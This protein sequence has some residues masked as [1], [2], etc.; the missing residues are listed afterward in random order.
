[1]TITRPEL[2]DLIEQAERNTHVSINVCVLGEVARYHAGKANTPPTVDVRIL[3]RMLLRNGIRFNP[4]IISRVPIGQWSFGPVVIRAVPEVGDGLVCHVF[5]REILTW[6]TKNPSDRKRNYDPVSRRTHDP[7]DIIAF[8]SIRP[9]LRNPSGTDTPRQIYIGHESGKG[10]HLKVNVQT[11][12]IALEASSTVDTKAGTS[13]TIEAA[14]VKLGGPTATLGVAR[15][16]DTVGADVTMATWIAAV[17]AFVNG[18]APGT[19][20]LPSDFGKVSS[21]SSKVKSE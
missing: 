12:A 7:N 1:M 9:N 4:E 19:A 16:T 13:T 10:T 6:L 11:G 8:P 2:A 21:A 14:S 20:I 15:I 3:P 5:D 18:A 17:T